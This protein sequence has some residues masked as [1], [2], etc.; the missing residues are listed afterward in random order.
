MVEGGDLLQVMPDSETAARKAHEY[1]IAKSTKSIHN[2]ESAS[3]NM[4][5]TR[6]KT[7][8]LKQLKVVLKCDSNGSLEAIKSA[9]G[10]LST[11]ETQVTFIHSGVGEVNDSDVLMAGTSQALLIA[12]NVSVN[13][14]ARHTLANSKIEFIDKKVI[15]HILEKV[16]AI[17]TGMVDLRF[18]NVELGSTKVK[19][20]FYSSKDRLI[21]GMEVVEGKIENKAKIRVIRNGEKIGN[22]EV[23]NLKT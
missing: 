7:G 11:D 6:I 22:G 14:H 15:Y 5:L 23:L 8:S 2:F 1:Q 19:A 3:L 12:Y 9:L 10:K 4:L 18:D 20:I 17:I 13:I 16:E 21:V